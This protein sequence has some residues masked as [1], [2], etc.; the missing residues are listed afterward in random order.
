MKPGIPIGKY[1]VISLVPLTAKGR[2]KYLAPKHLGGKTEPDFDFVWNNP[3]S[4]VIRLGLQLESG[5]ILAWYHCFAA[6]QDENGGTI[7]LNPGAAL[8]K[9]ILKL[10]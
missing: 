10:D 6:L 2:I 5:G 4:T 3:H 8:N 7:M 1:K 9:E